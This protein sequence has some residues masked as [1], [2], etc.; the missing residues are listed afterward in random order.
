[1]IGWFTPSIEHKEP[2]TKYVQL[3]EHKTQA[4]HQGQKDVP[5]L[6]PVGVPVL[7]RVRGTVQEICVFFS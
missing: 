1:M 4:M 2:H 5:K 3:A 6:S 7:K